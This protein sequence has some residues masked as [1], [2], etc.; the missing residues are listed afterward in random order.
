MVRVTD[1]GSPPLNTTANFTV[2]V[3]ESNS[4]PTLAVIGNQSVNENKHAH[5]HSGGE[6]FR[7]AGECADLQFARHGAGGASIN[8]SSGVF[9]WTPTEAQGPSVNSITVQVTDD[10]SPA[11]S[12]SRTF[13]VTVNQVNTAPVLPAIA[14]KT[15]K[16]LSTLSFAVS[17]TDSDIPANTLTYSLLGAVPS[18]ASIN[19]SSGVFTWTPTAA[20]GPSTNHSRCASWTMACRR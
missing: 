17:A 6:R 20:Q 7:S 19:A 5:V 3:N 14:D 13:T 10:G 2:V 8:P 1:N 18:G 12:F 9:T 4:P 15:I 16:E 11:L